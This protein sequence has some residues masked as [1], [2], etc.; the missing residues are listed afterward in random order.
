[1]KITLISDTHTLHKNIT[2]DLIGGDILIHAGDIMNS[3]HRVQEVGEFCEWFDSIDN[4]K[5]KI[6]I[7]GNHDRMFQYNSELVMDIIDSYKSITYLQ[8][9]F[10]IVDGL[11]IYGSPWQPEFFNWAFNL[12]RDGEE[13][14]AK[15][16]LIPSDV[17]ILITHGPAYGFVDQVKGKEEHLG[18]KLLS[19][20]IEEVKPRIHVCGHIHSGNGITLTNDTSYF[21]ASVLDERYYYAHKPLDISL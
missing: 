13:L 17:D 1:M 3:G 19:K 6:F 20:R 21:N 7:A 2:P 15:W 12:P 14:K 4:Y 5:T 16:D 18:C 9:S 11:K 8:D 10:V